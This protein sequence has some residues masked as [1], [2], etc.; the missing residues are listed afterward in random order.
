MSFRTGPFIKVACFC[1]HA[2]EGKDGVFSLVRVVDVINH[3]AQG[4]SVPDEMPPVMSDLKMV[5]MIAP[6]MARGRHNLT[7]VP[8]NPMGIRDLEHALALSVHFEEGRA[9]NLVADF[10][11][12]FDQEGMYLFHVLLD[13]EHMTSMPM[14]IR[15]KTIITSG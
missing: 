11:Y 3:Y 7:I 10:A 13:D 1:D 2:I 4:A 9:M 6:G 14:T 15:Y 8:E 5:V 12:R